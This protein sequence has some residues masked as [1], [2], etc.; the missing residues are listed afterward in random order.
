[1]VI[2]VCGKTKITQKDWFL[3]MEPVL[4]FLFSKKN[5]IGQEQNYYLRLSIYLQVSAS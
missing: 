2:R 5:F 3:Q 4:I 1:M